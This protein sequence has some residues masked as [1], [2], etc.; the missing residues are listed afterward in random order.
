VLT[1]GVGTQVANWL[2]NNVRL[3]LLIHDQAL[4]LL[5]CV[6]RFLL[7]AV[8]KIVAGGNVVNQ[9]NDLAGSPDLRGR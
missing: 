9:T 5:Q 2:S 6:E 8:Y 3:W 4:G 7:D 1:L